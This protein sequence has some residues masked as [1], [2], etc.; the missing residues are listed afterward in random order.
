MAF[1]IDGIKLSMQ[2]PGDEIRQS[3]F[4][5]GWTHGHYV[6]NVF[7]FAPDGRIVGMV[8]NAPGSFHDSSILDYG[9][10]YTRLEKLFDCHGVR[11]VVDSAF[12][13]EKK[14]SLLSRPKTSQ[15][16]I[17]FVKLPSTSRPPLYGSWPNGVWAPSREV[18]PGSKIILSLKRR[19]SVS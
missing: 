11:S 10:L 4:Y 14:T 3:A 16:R 19:V 15:S 2:K 6:G 9:R 7:V 18:C 12:L 13:V 5:N 8:I 17:I 1:A